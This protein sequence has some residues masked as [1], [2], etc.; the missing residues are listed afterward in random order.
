MLSEAKIAE[1]SDGCLDTSVRSSALGAERSERRTPDKRRIGRVSLVTKSFDAKFAST[2]M[3]CGQVPAR[4]NKCAWWSLQS[5]T[6][7]WFS[8]GAVQ[9]I[10]C[11]CFNV[12]GQGA[13]QD[14]RV[15]IDWA[16][17]APPRRAKDIRASHDGLARQ[18]AYA[19]APRF[20]SAPFLILVMTS[21]GVMP[22][23]GRRSGAEFRDADSNAVIPRLT[24]GRWRD[25]LFPAPCR[26]N[27][28]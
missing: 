11:A 3:P 22:R 26:L 1:T 15:G 12:V 21:G 4:G 7:T 25:R 2:E 6:G 14:H 19:G 10:G 17:S 13:R 5:L 24:L 8:G 20:A 16:S 23:Q 18:R 27:G 9:D 28:P